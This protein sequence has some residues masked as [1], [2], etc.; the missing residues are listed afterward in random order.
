VAAAA[1]AHGASRFGSAVVRLAPLV[2]AHDL[3]LVAARFP[4]LLPRDERAYVG[5]TIPADYQRAIERRVSTIREWHGFGQDVMRHSL[6]DASVSTPLAV[7]SRARGG[8]VAL[9]L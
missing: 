6:D 8:Q 2:K 3:A 5:T 4:V 1:K 7:R 9:P